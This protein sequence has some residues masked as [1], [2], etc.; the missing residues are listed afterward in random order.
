VAGGQRCAAF[1]LV[2][3][4]CAVGQLNDDDQNRA[5]WKARVKRGASRYVKAS[6]RL[7]EAADEKLHTAE[8][9]AAVGDRFAEMRRR[10][11]DA[12]QRQPSDADVAD[13][14]STA[15]FGDSLRMIDWDA[16][17]VGVRSRGNEVGV[18]IRQLTEGVDWSRLKP[19]ARKLALA[20]VVAIATEAAGEVIGAHASTLAG[21]IAGRNDLIGEAASSL[22][23]AAGVDL[24]SRLTSQFLNSEVLKSAARLAS[25]SHLQQLGVNWA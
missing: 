4:L 7:G 20:L 17:A 16:V 25:E 18:R 3:S 13:A 10:V 1:V 6:R 14:S 23:G 11:A 22:T 15:S 5:G 9:G 8:W 12:V 19:P 24:N 2:S 21:A